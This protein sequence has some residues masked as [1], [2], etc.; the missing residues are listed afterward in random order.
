M[1]ERQRGAGIGLI[2]QAFNWNEIEKTR[3]RFD[4]SRYD[5]YVGELARHRMAVLPIL[6][7][8]PSFRSSKPPH[9]GPRGTYPPRRP[10]EMAVFARLL[11]DRYGPTGSFWRGPRGLPRRPIRAWQ[12]WNEPNLVRYM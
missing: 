12:V 7:A 9:G 1:L 6:F 11:V 2:R 8:P 3:G 10:I 5:D 4:F